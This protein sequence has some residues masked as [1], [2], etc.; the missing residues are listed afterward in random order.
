MG[1]YL[2]DRWPAGDLW[3]RVCKF[4]RGLTIGDNYK[5]A[6]LLE[7]GDEVGEAITGEMVEAATGR[8][9]GTI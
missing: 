7:W 8:K 3:R 5:K 4:L 6:A 9:A 1:Y 2:A